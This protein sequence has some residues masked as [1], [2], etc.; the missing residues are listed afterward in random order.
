MTAD[1]LPTFEPDGELL[2]LP[3]ARLLP[4]RCFVR[5]RSYSPWNA[6]RATH[7][8]ERHV[9]CAGSVLT[10]TRAQGFDVGDLQR[11][12][13]E[14]I[15]LHRAEGLGEVCVQPLV[16]QDAQPR[17]AAPVASPRP[18]PAEPARPVAPRT[19]LVGYV[20][21]RLQQH[22]RPRLGHAWAREQLQALMDLLAGVRRF[23]GW[24]AAAPC[25]PAAAQ[26]GALADAVQGC[27]SLK[28]LR[29]RVLDGQ[30][31]LCKPTDPV[32]KLDCPGTGGQVNT[33]R[34]WVTQALDSLAG[35]NWDWSA[36]SY[37]W[38]WTCAEARRLDLARDAA[39]L[40]RARQRV[41]M[42]GEVA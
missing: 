29:A 19:P 31:A 8:T 38:Q 26:W 15:G 20:Q 14:G 18:R 23:N 4:Q 24:P 27:D 7:E 39:T 41:N 1:G 5:T 22:Q 28:A 2:G 37:A 30:G 36:A 3:G 10:L 12:Q 11:L 6:H 21:S 34:G 32:W 13:Q 16:L 35:P 25:G 42:E 33:L 40:Q 9:L 17:F